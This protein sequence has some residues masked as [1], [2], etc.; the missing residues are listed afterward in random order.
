MPSNWFDLSLGIS[1]TSL[2]TVILILKSYYSLFDL[3]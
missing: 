1:V 3:I 2:D